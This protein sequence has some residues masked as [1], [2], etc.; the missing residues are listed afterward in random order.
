MIFF[1][2]STIRFNTKKETAAAAVKINRFAQSVAIE[3]N[4]IYIQLF[5]EYRRAWF[6][7]RGYK[8]NFYR[9]EVSAANNFAAVADRFNHLTFSARAEFLIFTDLKKISMF[10][11]AVAEDLIGW[12]SLKKNTISRLSVAVILER[13]GA[14]TEK[15]NGFKLC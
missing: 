3:L 15:I 14:I 7:L 8:M 13:L 4:E 6:G 12:H 2:G 1:N 9:L 10:L 11:A 5:A